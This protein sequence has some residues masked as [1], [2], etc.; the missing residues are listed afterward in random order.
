MFTATIY[1]IFHGSDFYLG[2]KIFQITREKEEIDNERKM[3]G[4]L[5]YEQNPNKT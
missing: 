4:I 1:S 3:K 5:K 2:K